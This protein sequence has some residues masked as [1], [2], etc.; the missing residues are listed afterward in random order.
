MTLVY[1]LLV[2]L[3]SRIYWGIIFWLFLNR[4]DGQ[5]SLLVADYLRPEIRT[6]SLTASFEKYTHS[7]ARWPDPAM[8]DE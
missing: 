7:V 1:R 4:Y 6:T 8:P 3:S 2:P 5:V